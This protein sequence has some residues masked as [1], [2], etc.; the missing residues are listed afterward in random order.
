MLVS[1]AGNVIDVKP[2]LLNAKEPMVV[3]DAGRWMDVRLVAP[4]K[5]F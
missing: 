1:E 5:A 4:L 3:S 2:V